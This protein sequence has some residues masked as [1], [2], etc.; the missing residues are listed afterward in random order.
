MRQSYLLARALN[1]LLGFVSR[2]E[3]RFAAYSICSSGVI[4]VFHF[5]IATLLG[6]EGKGLVQATLVVASFVSLAALPG[7]TPA[8]M[9]YL[10]RD[11][12]VLR[13]STTRGGVLV[14]T[15]AAVL[16]TME[17]PGYALGLS[18]LVQAVVVTT[19]TGLGQLARSGRV[20]LFSAAFPCICGGGAALIGAG[21]SSVT[22]TFVVASLVASIAALRGL[23]SEGRPNVGRP[24]IDAGSYRV[25]AGM[26]FRYALTASPGILAG[27]LIYRLDQLYLAWQGQPAGLGN[28]SLAVQ[29]VEVSYVSVGPLATLLLRR[30]SEPRSTGLGTIRRVVF[31]YAAWAFG[32]QVAVIG[33]F[34]GFFA[35]VQPSLFPDFEPVL[36][37]ALV[38]APA[39][40]AMGCAKVF[41]AALNGM[42]APGVASRTAIFTAML[43]AVLLVL[44]YPAMGLRG[45][46][47]ASLIAY[48]A[49]GTILLYAI[50][51]R[52]FPESK[53]E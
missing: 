28:Y 47:I 27:A 2:G 44:L 4:A 48:G 42:G 10:P 43:N 17:Q 11:P 20:Q 3:S 9:H 7:L 6:P 24:P 40:L 49:H 39:A 18:L 13:R 52:T 5:L 36:G 14:I 16:V 15:A 37:L 12:A 51:N 46:A 32:A 25:D 23:C 31:R 41:A 33:A 45:L 8:L 50:F 34:V 21:A 29:L 26:V 22:Y 53:E 19:R 35:L 38:L 1:A 30:L